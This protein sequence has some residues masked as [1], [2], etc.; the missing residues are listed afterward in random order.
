MLTKRG[1]L[2]TTALF[3]TREATSILRQGL[4]YHMRVRLGISEVK[5]GRGADSP[6]SGDNSGTQ[7]GSAVVDPLRTRQ[8]STFQIEFDLLAWSFDL[9]DGRSTLPGPRSMSVHGRSTS[10][11]A[12]FDV[13]R[14]PP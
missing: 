4:D 6:A 7:T 13:D 5:G 1:Q 9:R 2:L 10:I 11:D 12:H 3:A 8:S 14:R